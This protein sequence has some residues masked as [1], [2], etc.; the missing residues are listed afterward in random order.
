MKLFYLVIPLLWVALNCHGALDPLSDDELEAT[1]GQAFVGLDNYERDNLNYSRITF[2]MEM[3]SFMNADQAVYGEF[4]R[5]GEVQ[6]A[7][8]DYKNFAMGYID[9]NREIRPFKM[10]DPYVEVAYEKNAITG[11]NDL[12]GFRLG[13]G[14]SQGLLSMD[15]SAFTGNI[16]VV[17]SGDFTLIDGIVFQASGASELLTPSGE[18]DPVRA[19][20][21][22]ISNYDPNSGVDNRFEIQIPFILK[23]GAALLAATKPNDSYEANGFFDD[24]TYKAAVDNCDLSG[25]NLCYELNTFESMM[26]GDANGNPIDGLFQSFQSKEVV[27]GNSAIGEKEVV[28]GM[29]A[30]FNIPRGAIN[31]TPDEAAAGTP[32]LATEFIDRGVG[33]FENAKYR[34]GE[35]Q[36]PE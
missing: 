18:K 25:T 33:R 28:S 30:F 4:P 35:V 29:G 13:F 16:D 14:K 31:L 21:I 11:V 36:Y 7:D 15:A 8:L 19:T 1:Q 22:G 34:N 23:A 6:T 17:I 2:G 20:H 26:I 3:E 10:I 12:V 5:D 32:R 27:W 24:G 9:E